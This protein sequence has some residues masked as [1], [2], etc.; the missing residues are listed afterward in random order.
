M[1]PCAM[2][3]DAMVAEDGQRDWMCRVPTQPH[4]RGVV[5]WLGRTVDITI[6]RWNL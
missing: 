4:A 3:F 2:S 1:T 6:M 5:Y